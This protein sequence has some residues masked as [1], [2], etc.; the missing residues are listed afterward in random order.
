MPITPDPPFP[1]SQGDNIRSKDWNDTVNEVIRLDAAKL[2]LTGGRITG[3][4][5]VSGPL[6][7]AG[8]LGVGTLTP[9]LALTVEGGGGTYLNVRALTGGPFEVLLG[10]DNGGGILS[11]MT[12]HD[13]QI[14]SG[15]NNTR[16]IVKAD[17]KIGIG[18]LT[19]GA[20]L[21]V[22]DFMCVGPFS[23]TAGAGGIDVTGPVAEFGFV[24]REL[25]SWPA[26]PAAGDRYVW[27]NQGS[28]ARLFTE[29]NGDL[30]TMAPDG[31]M[32]LTR[33]PL[34]IPRSGGGF[35]SI[36]PNVFSNEGALVSPNLKVNM[37][38]TGLFIIGG[39]PFAYQFMVGHTFTNFVLG[40]GGATNFMRVF[41]VDQA[42][43]AFFAA[44]KGGY[45]VDYFVNAVGDKVE[46]GD[47]VILSSAENS[48]RYG[49]NHNIPIP[50]V[51]LC[52]KA[53]DTRVCG[54]VADLVKEGELPTVMPP[55]DATQEFFD[56]HPYSHM[57]GAREQDITQ[58]HDRQMGRMV[59]LGAYAHCKVDAN[60]ASIEAGDLLTTSRTR[61]HAQKAADPGRALGTIVG[62]ALAP[63]KSGR[64]KIPIL[65]MLQ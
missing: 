42:G 9:N 48:L 57:A 55:E 6:T 37:G 36:G 12:N 65:V 54:I 38:N 10:A 51:D 30:L 39:L 4:L 17:G 3:Q 44:G 49:T 18:T 58:I 50:E 7:T 61:G 62:K 1:K 20:P 34:Q 63:L 21:H 29:V 43:N 22:A 46:Q 15:S 53:Y 40:G 24:R 25:T 59:T 64:G 35:A 23:A 47:V 8:R 31:T 45:V 16:M 60:V 33:G 13:L 56:R 19:P 41:S 14:R 11:V 5:D 52:T 2:N 26:T 28:V 32:Q 27:Y